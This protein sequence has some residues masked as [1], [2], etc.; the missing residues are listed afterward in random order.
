MQS[1]LE[2]LEGLAHKLLVDVPAERVDQAVESRLKEIRPRVRIDG[3]RPGKIPPQVIKQKYGAGVRMDVVEKLISEALGEALTEKELRPVA[4]PEVNV[5]S[6]LK[7]GETL[8][9]EAV[10]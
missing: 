9:F 5:V 1:S 3:F 4:P 8:K 2:K 10:F 7:E 6:G